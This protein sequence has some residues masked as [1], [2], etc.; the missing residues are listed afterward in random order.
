MQHKV[1]YGIHTE[2]LNQIIRIDHIAFGFAHLAVSLKKPGMSEHLLRQ[3]LSQCHQEDRPVDRME[4]DDI[5]ADQMQVGRPQFPVLLTV[6]P[7]RIESNTGNIIRQGIHPHIDHMFI[8]EI[9]R[10]SP[11]IGCPGH[12]QVLQARK[13]EVIHHLV[14]AGYRLNEFRMCVYMLDQLVRIFAHLEEIGFFLSRF[15]FSAAIRALAVHQLGFCPE[16]FTRCAVHAFV[17]AFVNI[18]LVIQL[19]EDLLYLSLMIVIRRTDKFIIGSIQR[20][21]DPADLTRHMI[22]K[23]LRCYPL[24][25]CL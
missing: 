7:V 23:L 20:I 11:L 15:H 9:Y 24:L 1:P 25:L 4:A 3:R 6:L 5:L 2:E 12:A 17:I 10:N 19:P 18:S 13:Q 8:V 16:R 14:L 21:T 22:H